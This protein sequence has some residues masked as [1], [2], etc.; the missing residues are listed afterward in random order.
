M[1][2]IWGTGTESEALNL[3]S[4]AKLLTWGRDPDA[5]DAFLPAATYEPGPRRR[6]QVVTG[7]GGEGYVAVER[8]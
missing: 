7:S 1:S 5:F 4:A 3:I 2:R 6:G 8:P